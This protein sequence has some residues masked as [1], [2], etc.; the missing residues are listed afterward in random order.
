MTICFLKK[1]RTKGYNLDRRGGGNDLQRVGERETVIKIYSMKR[2]LFSI[3]EKW[4]EEYIVQSTL[5][6]FSDTY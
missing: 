5:Y 4:E 6:S 2:T 1:K 3:K